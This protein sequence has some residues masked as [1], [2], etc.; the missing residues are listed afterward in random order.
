MPPTNNKNQYAEMVK[1][2]LE[3]MSIKKNADD[4]IKNVQ[5]VLEVFLKMKGA[6]EKERQEIRQLLEQ[7]IA[8]LKRTGDT[9]FESIKTRIETA[10]NRA[11]KE[12]EN[13]LNFIR[14][15]ARK[16]ENGR[17]GK[18]GADGKDGKDGINGK[19][20]SPDTGEQIVDKIQELNTEPENQIGIE[21]IK[22]W[23]EELEKIRA[24][25]IVGGGGFSVMA[26]EQHMVDGETPGGTVNGVTTDFTLVNT[27]SPATSLKVYVNGQRMRI[28]EDYT[29]SGRTITFLIAP[30]TG[31]I[32]LADYRV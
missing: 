25:R 18:D 20:G 5:L 3:T 30:P 14:D 13:S 11:L 28:T 7:T 19:D 1:T 4:L 31:S 22:G 12:Q 27:P 26:M 6:N 24:T 10:L 16:L 8:D 17:D 15:K 2:M 21:H 29:F 9:N 23:K 32:L